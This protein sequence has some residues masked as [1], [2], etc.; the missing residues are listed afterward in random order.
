MITKTIT[1]S[2]RRVNATSIKISN[3][4]D[5]NAERIKFVLPARL[6][7]ASVFLFLSI[8]NHSDVVML[9]DE[10][11]F[12]PERKHTQYPGRWTAY[13]EAQ[14]DGDVVWHS[15]PFGLIVGDLPDTGE[16]IE[17][18]YPTAVEQAMKAAAE[19]AKVTGMTARA[20]E[21][22]AGAEP[23]ADYADGV[24][25]I[26]IPLG[27]D[28][29]E[30]QVA[31][32]VAD[33]LAA[34]PI[35]ESDP[36]VPAWAK[37]E[38]KPSYTAS[39]VGADPSGTA[40]AQV[41]AHNTG[42][43]THSD[44]RLLI[45]G[46]S[47]RLNA[48]ADSDD[49]TLD[50]L[51]EV[52]AYIKSNR[53]LISAI[54]TDKVSVADIIDNLTTNVAN[55]PLSAAQGVAL[56]ALIDAITIPEALPNP[57]ALTFTGAVT[58]SYDGSSKM[59][60]RIPQV[61]SWA[62]K[63]LFDKADLVDPGNLNSFVTVDGVEYY[64]Y[65]AGGTYGFTWNNPHPIPGSVTITARGV[66]QYGGSGG[67][68]LKTIYDDGTYGPD[69]HI[70]VSGESKT[71]TVTTDA[72]KTLAKITGNYDLENWV[73]LDMSVM[74]IVAN[75]NVGVPLADSNVPGGI[76]ADP[77]TETDTV[78]AKIGADGKLYV[79]DM[80][81]VSGGTASGDY[82]PV[83]S[84]AEVGQTIV[85]KAVDESGKPTE[86][87][88][89]DMASGG[90]D[91]WKLLVDFESTEEIAANTGMVFDT[92]DDGTPINAK[93]II[94]DWYCPAATGPAYA[95]FKV[96]NVQCT[97]YA[98]SA[99]LYFWSGVL[100]NKDAKAAALYFRPLND[101]CLLISDIKNASPEPI[102]FAKS[103]AFK[104]I[105]SLQLT[106]FGGTY[107]VGLKIKILGR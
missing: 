2:D 76:K 23:T 68:R 98:Q 20:V 24:L 70:V 53:D 82:I 88:A 97:G 54:T 52:V 18:A 5:N 87:A 32:A 84:T 50:Q 22:P 94:I 30:A 9:D 34:H 8:E 35:K 40:A 11:T 49:T 106:M 101:V 14:Q 51:S 48:L 27:G 81:G 39:E 65:H 7:S 104:A 36:T 44:I 4:G 90:G 77:A 103:G 58:G 83:P 13:L 17:Q 10:R 67:T 60:A 62:N 3:E 95:T 96:N 71:A 75:Y 74:S 38:Q 37:A 63:E 42:P 47:D 86:W 92:A 31:Q 57:N 46:L 105:T 61:V 16:R 21:L 19:A 29:S 28:V 43:D 107:P 89:A 100:I 59:S 73:L 55:K 33:Y 66:S 56:K 85:V 64:R 102:W 15:D 69:L 99:P 78:P 91:N 41:A 79:P 93:E 1:F 72:S 26:G 45:Q 25:T 12:T 80:S 6:A